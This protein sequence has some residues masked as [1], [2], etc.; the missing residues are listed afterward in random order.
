MH[1]VKRS[2]RSS[3]SMMALGITMLSAMT[4]VANSQDANGAKS[5]EVVTVTGSRLTTGFVTPTPVTAVSAQSLSEAAPNSVAEGLQQLP[6]LS[7][8]S[9]TTTPITAAT[10]QNGQA[11][12]NLRG[13]GTNEN[14]VL[15]DGRR[16]VATNTNNSVDLNTL[17]QNLIS[18]VDVVTG[19]ASAAYGSDAVAGVINLVLDTKFTGLKGQV[20]GGISTYGDLGSYKASLA[21]GGTFLD[22]RLHVIASTDYFNQ[23]GIPA[24]HK[25]GRAWFD[26][27]AGL[28]PNTFSKQPTNIVVPDIRSSIG[29]Y[30]GLITNTALAGTQFLAGGAP[31]PFDHGY[32]AGKGFQ[33][34]GDGAKPNI[35]FAPDQ[36]RSTNFLHAEYSI[37]DDD[38]IYGEAGYSYAYSKSGNEVAAETG[39]QFA[40]TIFSGNPFIPTSIQSVMTANHISQFTL[41]RYMGEY[42]LINIIDETS[43]TR[44][45]IGIQGSNAFGMSDWHYDVSYSSGQTHQYLPE[46]NL[47]IARN[48]YAAADA[49][50]NPQNGQIVCRSQYYDASGNFVPGGTGL[51]AGCQPINLFGPGSVAPSAIP[52]T[53]GDSWKALA[54]R[55]NVWQANLSGDFGPDFQ[56]GAG[57]ISFGVGAEYRQESALQTTDQLSPTTISFAGVRGG[58]AALNG[59]KGPFRF[60]NP[61]PFSGSYDVKEA[62]AELG[63]PLLRDLPFAESLNADIA[64]R[65]TQYSLAGDVTTWK[66]GLDYQVIDDVRFR[67]TVSQDIRAPNLLELF[68]T[69]SQSSNNQLYPSSTT[70]STTPALT[71]SS[72]NPNLKPEKALTYT[73]GVVLTPRF[74]DGL[75][76][77]VDYYNI[78]VKGA[79][80]NIS[81]QNT[82]DF[83]YEGQAAYCNLVSYNA[84]TVR[85]LLPLLNL[86]VLDTAG[87]D[88]EATYL[89]Q[90]FGN[91][92]QLHL[93]ANHITANYSQ[94]PNSPVLS[95]KGSDTA[96]S[97]RIT[98][99]ARYSIENL[100]LFLQERY[101]SAALMDATKV[102]GV[103]TNNNH[104]PHE[105]Y[106][107]V[108]ATYNLDAFGLSN[109]F[110]LSVNNLFNQ[111]PPLDLNPP[112]TFSQPTNR[113]VYDGIGRYFSAGI[114]FKM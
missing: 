35:G 15:L 10:G 12:L 18:H 9:L 61:L 14:L 60:Y 101:I 67:G 44:E 23:K 91:D 98:A 19:G 97:W 55:Q 4:G 52:F 105:F 72:G 95:T 109:Q 103:F 80:G 66:Y 28:I 92:L 82:I 31:A 40:F 51:D 87:Y 33:S 58:P 93:L 65:H 6:E 32:D 77:S 50:V 112:T 2:L 3:A 88:F 71:I 96:P 83:C 5:T 13:L 63:I 26:N 75:S 42:P 8:S 29:T 81:A 104:V 110:Y 39:A 48:M 114:R 106:T 107:D 99:Q 85:V 56:L 22:G 108:T 41:G 113:S 90:L 1:C 111:N 38:T 24:N 73:Y 94:A 84:G 37:T 7:L 45:A 86:N 25:T 11:L 69:A 43:V 68:N 100:S 54:L 76:I 34:G 79:I 49:V 16:V 30:G 17:P 47:P 74:L 36:W 64:A 70:G 59:K 62:Y 21:W 20:G 78:K 89:T 102:E 57:R 53:I 46:T 27:A